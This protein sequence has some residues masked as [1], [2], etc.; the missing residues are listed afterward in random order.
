MPLLIIYR[1]LPIYRI[2]LKHWWCL[3]NILCQR[4]EYVRK[5]HAGSEEACQIDSS[6]RA[7]SRHAW[8]HRRVAGAAHVPEKLGIA[9]GQGG[10]TLTPGGGRW[11]I[12]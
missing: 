10:G 2:R 8:L 9:P 5:E 1:T 7:V 3:N 11:G 12:R 4:S 6:V